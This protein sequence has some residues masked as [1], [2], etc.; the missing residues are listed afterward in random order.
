VSPSSQE[1]PVSPA[2]LDALALRLVEELAAAWHQGR[3][4]A[5]E[6][7]LSRHPELLASP[8]AA[9]QLIYEEVCLREEAGEEHAAAEVVARFP[10]WR[11]EL[12]VLLDCH[13]LLQRPELAGPVFPEVG[14]T[15]GDFRLVRELGRGAN[16]RVFLAAQP[17]LA[18]RPVV[19]KVTPCD[20]Q[21]HLALA[22]LQ[23][24]FIVPLYHVCDFPDRRLR[25]L[26]MP[27]LG[28]ATLGQVLAALRERP[29]AGR[30]GSDLLR[31]LD[32]LQRPNPVP[33]QPLRSPAREFFARA[34]YVDA[35]CILGEFLGEALQYAHERDL[36]HLDVKPSNVLLA[37]DAQPMLLDFHLAR[38]PLRCGQPVPE[39]FGG[40]PDYMSPEQLEVL[41]AV[42]QRRP[43]PRDVGPR[44]DVYSLGLVLHEA[45]SGVLPARGA[46]PVPLHH[47]NPQVSRG[48]SDLVHRC[49]AAAPADRYPSTGAVA[50][51]LRR[52]REHRPLR[53]V[54][55]RWG[56]RWRKWR[57]RAPHALLRNVL[58]VVA[59]A[60]LLGLVGLG[61]LFVGDRLQKGR[62]ALADG[63]RQL[64]QQHYE[65]AE[66]TL[67]Q[68]L[69]AVRALPWGE[70]L[71]GQLAAEAHLAGRA[72]FA[73]GL[74]DIAERV[75]FDYG[76]MSLPPAD[77]RGR[78]AECRRFWD[79]HARVL[80]R[81]RADLGAAAEEQVGTDLLD[82][83][84][85]WA[86][87]RA[88]LA[89]READPGAGRR[90]V[91][92]VLEEAET[93]FGASPA[94]ARQR[95][96]CAAA[97]GDT[98]TAEAAARQA[99]QLE[100]RTALEH[101]ALGRSLL[102]A[103]DLTRA[104][105]E[106]A[107]AADLEPGGF[108]PHWERGVCLYRLRQYDGAAEAFRICTAL[109][110]DSAECFYQLGRVEAAA[111]QT[112]AAIHDYERALRR[113]PALSEAAGNRDA[114]LRQLQ[115]E[116][117]VP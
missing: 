5:A 9:A 107:W 53:G 116:R 114:L 83:A 28:G 38:P 21:E 106:L 78:L 18:D 103:G 36:L 1:Y 85:F 105:D 48:L 16:G 47:G 113:N 39:W 90:E 46:V 54:R 50:A 25:A 91:L 51:D 109:A 30:S 60:L 35:V 82:L 112:R 68:G 77:A 88:R 98:A 22:R 94:V 27:Y 34:S 41:E 66:K 12:E 49:L 75:R 74:H 62:S 7:F 24:T 31:E 65:D 69:E 45:L 29:P 52:H 23:H 8:Q 44:S 3:R 100:P 84:L 4:V 43:V 2:G 63:R 70:D 104:A 110:P 17:A 111:R 56:E 57:R 6:D 33:P 26:S 73:H 86:D 96:A 81:S 80:D 108:W 93:T 101:Y 55:T 72:H 59:G 102:A 71:A 115:R 40:T 20:G 99:S 95:Q 37:A 67:K 11:T 97:L 15:L 117:D 42:R 89:A 32:R 10:Q 79:A 87:Q 19:V 64:A 58:L 13:R 92:R 76:G 14:A 61:R